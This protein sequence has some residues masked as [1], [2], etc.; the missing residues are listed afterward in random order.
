MSNGKQS[1]NTIPLLSLTKEFLSTSTKSINKP[2]GKRIISEWII[3]RLF[4]KFRWRD[5]ACSK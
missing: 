1:E 4:V 5:Y 2:F 3:R